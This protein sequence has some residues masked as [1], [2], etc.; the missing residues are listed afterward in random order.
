VLFVKSSDE[1]DVL[2]G[3]VTVITRISQY[4]VRVGDGQGYML[5]A[6]D[7]LHFVVTYEVRN[8]VTLH[9]ITDS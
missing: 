7:K 2:V 4:I 1:P 8:T 9:K 6:Y 5:I 3:D